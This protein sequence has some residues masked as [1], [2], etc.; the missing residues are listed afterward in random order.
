MFNTFSQA[1]RKLII[2]NHMKIMEAW[3]QEPCQLSLLICKKKKKKVHSY[4][5]ISKLIQL[6]AHKISTTFNLSVF[7][8]FIPTAH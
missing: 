3:F 2:F 8:S 7:T 6:P 5:L 4:L 1:S